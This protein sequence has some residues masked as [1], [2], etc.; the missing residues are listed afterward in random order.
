MIAVVVARV[1][2][3]LLPVLWM[4]SCSYIMETAGENQRQRVCFVEFD[5]QVAALGTQSQYQ[6][7]RACIPSRVC[8]RVIDL[9]FI[10]FCT[11]L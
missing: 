10:D 3:Y 7:A 5:P 4:M 8:V 9:L 11:F 2:C 6:S 1:T